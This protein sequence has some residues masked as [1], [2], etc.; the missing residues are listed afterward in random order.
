VWFI[1]LVHIFVQKFCLRLKSKTTDFLRNVDNYQPANTALHPIKTVIMF[2]HR[3]DNLKCHSFVCVCNAKE[4]ETTVGFPEEIWCL[5]PIPLIRYIYVVQPL[6]RTVWGKSWILTQDSRCPGWGSIRRAARCEAGIVAAKDVPASLSRPWPSH[7]SA[8]RTDRRPR[9]CGDADVQSAWC[10]PTDFNFGNE[11]F[12]LFFCVLHN[13]ELT[14][15]Y[16]SPNIIRASKLRRIRWV[17]H[18]A[19]MG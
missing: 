14:D 8:G 6:D 19:R 12:F 5:N 4:H 9:A 16:C 17:G 1:G 2:S 3:S 11:F 18:V 15:L 7:V 13:E 10:R